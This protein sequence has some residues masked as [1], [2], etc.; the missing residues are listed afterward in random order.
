KPKTKNG[1]L[2]HFAFRALHFA[3]FTFLYTRPVKYS[4]QA[5]FSS[6]K[7]SGKQKPTKK[8]K[9][10][11]QKTNVFKEKNSYRHHFGFCPCGSQLVCDGAGQQHHR[12]AA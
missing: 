11:N 10:G 6:I 8:F 9:R 1:I 2:L 4:D 12:A 5:L 3:L 7:R